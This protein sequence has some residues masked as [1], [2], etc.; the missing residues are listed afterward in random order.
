MNLSKRSIYFVYCKVSFIVSKLRQSAKLNWIFIPYSS[1]SYEYITYQYDGHIHEPICGLCVC[2]CMFV[3]VLVSI[4]VGNLTRPKR[5]T[6]NVNSTNKQTHTCIVLLTHLG[7][8]CS[9]RWQYI[10]I[11][12]YNIVHILYLYH[13]SLITFLHN[14]LKNKQFS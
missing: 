3:Y 12:I 13:N 8:L 10:Q 5:M 11:S 4:E 14:A 6:T 1:K 2:D 9:F 7:L